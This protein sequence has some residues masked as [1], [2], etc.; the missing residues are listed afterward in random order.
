MNSTKVVNGSL[1]DSYK[2]IVI[3]SLIHRAQWLRGRALDSRL[4]EPGFKSCAVVLKP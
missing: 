4:R 2:N 1:K 3:L